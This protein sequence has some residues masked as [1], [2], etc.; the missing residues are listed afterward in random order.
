MSFL[1]FVSAGLLFVSCASFGFIRTEREKKKLGTIKGLI[2][3]LKEM[4]HEVR[5]GRWDTAVI[6]SRLVSSGMEKDIWREAVRKSEKGGSF[7][8]SLMD[9][10]EKLIDPSVSELLG[11]HLP[12][13]C[14]SDS[15]AEAERIRSAADYLNEYF[16]IRKAKSDEKNKLTLSLSI[17]AGAAAAITVL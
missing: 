14:S 7:R 17:L 13:V 4:E 5:F 10:V 1:R 12:E 3:D 11:K 16:S 8:R 15:C 9:A 6:L 2:T